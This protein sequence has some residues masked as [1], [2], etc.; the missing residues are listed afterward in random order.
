MTI[1]PQGRRWVQCSSLLQARLAALGSSRLLTGIDASGTDGLAPYVGHSSFAVP[2]FVAVPRGVSISLTHG[3]QIC[4]AISR[5][6]SLC[7]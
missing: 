5:S 7:R 1:G 4:D 2:S 6:F 3:P